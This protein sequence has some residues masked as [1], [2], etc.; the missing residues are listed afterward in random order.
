MDII[1]SVMENKKKL[2]VLSVL[3]ALCPGAGRGTL[4]PAYA[5]VLLWWASVCYLFCAAL[6]H[7][8]GAGLSLWLLYAL[9]AFL[10]ADGAYFLPRLF[11]AQE[12]RVVSQTRSERRV[13]AL[14][15]VGISLVALAV[16]AFTAC[17]LH[18]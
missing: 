3:A 14:Q 17:W 13:R 6:W 15:G 10:V 5:N 4:L 12:V 1:K 11:P 7:G 18:G 8:L 2:F 16:I 9:V